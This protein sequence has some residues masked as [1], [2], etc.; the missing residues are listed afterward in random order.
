MKTNTLTRSVAIAGITLATAAPVMATDLRIDGFISVVAGTTLNEGNDRSQSDGKA[1]FTADSPTAGVYDGDFDLNPDSI[2]GLQVSTELGQNLSVTGQIT[3]TGGEDFGARVSWAY[4]SY[5]FSDDWTINAGR[6]RIPFFLYSDFLDVGYAYHW[7]RAPTE[8]QVIFDSIDGLQLT[9]Q[10]TAGDWDSRFQIYGGDSEA[11][12]DAIGDINLDNAV[13]AVYYTSNTWLQ[14]RAT[15]AAGEFWGND[16]ATQDEDNRVDVWFAGVA[17]HATFGNAFVV[18]EYVTYEFDEAIE[19]IGWTDYQGAYISLGYRINNITPHI[20][21]SL[22]KQDVENAVSRDAGNNILDVVTDSSE[23]SE[24]FTVG[25]RWDFHRSA[26][27]KLEYQ[28]RS[29]KSDNDFKT[30]FGERNEVDLLSAGFDI[31]F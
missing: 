26:A 6:Q 27:F 16:L 22:S 17:A 15:Y 14:L 8:T 9:W 20:T 28:T 7:M 21:Y 24:S 1:R 2:Y 4:I 18:T 11:D 12:S 3:G 25:V 30:A 10:G 19:E 23:Q 29:D 5:A 13:G 31:I